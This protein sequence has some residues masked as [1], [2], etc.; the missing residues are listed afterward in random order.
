M[1]RSQF[2]PP[3]ESP[4][5]G[6]ITD[7]G[8]GSPVEWQGW[9]AIRQEPAA[10][11]PA[12]WAGWTRG[13]ES[14]GVPVQSTPSDEHLSDPSKPGF[15]A[16]VAALEAS[17]PAVA[18]P[19]CEASAAV[20]QRSALGKRTAVHDS[21]LPLQR[22]S[23][24]LVEVVARSREERKFS[25]GDYTATLR[26]GKAKGEKVD[27]DEITDEGLGKAVDKFALSLTNIDYQMDLGMST[28]A[29]YGMNTE[30]RLRVMHYNMTSERL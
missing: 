19:L 9:S 2:R 25:L 26:V 12:A 18:V 23:H 8:Y 10:V 30:Y 11:E 15:L 20:G 1:L 21:M 29:F 17:E 7:P 4:R 28:E 16:G 24:L 14:A 6:L 5:P 27:G 3:V 22:G 13:E